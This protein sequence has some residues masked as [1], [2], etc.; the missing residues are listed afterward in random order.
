MSTF[1][2][3]PVKTGLWWRKSAGS[4]AHSARIGSFRLFAI[5][6]GPDQRLKAF[7][8]EHHVFAIAKAFEDLRIFPFHAE[9]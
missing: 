1:T 4:T 9:L 8:I 2:C 7:H 5:A 6:S 3:S